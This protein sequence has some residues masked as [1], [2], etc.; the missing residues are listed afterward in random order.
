MKKKYI[1][2]MPPKGYNRD[3]PKKLRES[4]ARMG[5]TPQMM[6]ERKADILEAWRN[7]PRK[8]RIFDIF[9]AKGLVVG[10]PSIDIAM[11]EKALELYGIARKR[12]TT[13][14]VPHCSDDDFFVEDPN[15]R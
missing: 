3:F 15:D 7:R 10:G 13:G 6:Q 1:R 5:I 2:I 12:V 11:E 9:L 4:A 8:P 14:A